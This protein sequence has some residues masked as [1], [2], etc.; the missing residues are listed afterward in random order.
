[1]SALENIIRR[2]NRNG[3]FYNEETP[4]P[5]L[6]LEEFFK[7]NDIIGSI[8][9]NLDGEPHPSEFESVLEKI[10]QSPNV[11]EVYI[12]VTEMDDPDW[13]FSDTAW[14]VTT[15]TEDD[16]AK[17]FPPEIAPDEVWEGFIEN[18]SYEEID[19][20]SNYKVLACWWD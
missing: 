7:G 16:I 19:I 1:M 14:V 15:A 4:I 20:P 6:T 5:L 3:E 12:Q 2:V 8:G 9:C 18:Q 13:P 17:C 11:H 10:K